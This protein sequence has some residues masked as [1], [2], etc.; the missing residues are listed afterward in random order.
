MISATRPSAMPARTRSQRCMEAYG[1][2]DHN[3]QALRVVTLLERRY[4]R[5]DGLDLTFETLEGIVKHNGPAARPARES[6]ARSAMY[7]EFDASFPLEPRHIRRASRR[8]RRL[9]PTTS[10][11]T[12]MTSTTACA[13]ACFRSRTSR[14]R[15]SS[16]G[17]SRGPRRTSRPRT[18][19]GHSRAGA[20]RHHRLR[21]GRDRRIA[22]GWRA[23]PPASA[24]NARRAGDATVAFS[25]PMAEAE[26]EIK[27]F[28]FAHMYRHEKVVG[29]WERARDVI[30]RLFPVFFEIPG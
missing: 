18:D 30:S 28:L 14:E 5:Y 1:G 10:P 4:A 15:P 2:F 17:C 9:S 7:A 29:V 3:A 12:P 25:P 21:R 6:G 16:P 24:E 22:R 13:P 26:R 19:A 11:I 23:A 8:R 27:A 20:P